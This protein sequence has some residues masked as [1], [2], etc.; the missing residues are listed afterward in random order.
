MVNDWPDE[1]REALAESARREKAREA[2]RVGEI[3]RVLAALDADRVV[4]VLLGDAALAYSVYPEPQLRTRENTDLLVRRAAVADIVRILGEIGYRRHR[5]A[6]E[7]RV[8]HQ[9]TYV[10]EEDSGDTHILDLHWAIDTR[11]ALADGFD[12]GDIRRR[13]V[14]VNALTACAMAACH[15]DALLLAC[16]RRRARAGNETLIGLYDIHLLVESMTSIDFERFVRSAMDMRMGQASRDAIAEAR[17]RFNTHL[18]SG[19]LEDH[20]SAEALADEARARLRLSPARRLRKLLAELGSF[21][22]V[23]EKPALT[24]GHD[25]PPTPDAGEEHPAHAGAW[26]PAFHFRRGLKSITAL[27]KRSP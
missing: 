25:V 8:L 21:D 3:R 11:P 19:E 6:P 22:R 26:L 14:A 4:P 7:Q 27:L 13:A 23:R 5:R 1:I 16:L 2:S 20:F 17:R 9:D 24:P 12:Y 15:E 10:R 18:P